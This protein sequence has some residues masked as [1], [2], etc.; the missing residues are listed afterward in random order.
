MKLSVGN[1]PPGQRA[2]VR[3]PET[4]RRAIKA[5]EKDETT[6]SYR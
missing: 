5:I 3:M 6:K 4:A 1:Y 2:L